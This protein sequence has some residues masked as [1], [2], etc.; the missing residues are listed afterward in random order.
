MDPEDGSAW[1]QREEDSG[2]IIPYFVLVI[3]YKE[4]L[5][6]FLKSIFFMLMM[7]LLWFAYE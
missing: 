3:C 5:A 6:L 7:L 2:D 4:T 1:S